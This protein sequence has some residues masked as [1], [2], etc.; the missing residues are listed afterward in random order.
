VCSSDLKSYI[1]L[2]SLD[3]KLQV[4]LFYCILLP[5]LYGNQIPYAGHLAE[6][7]AFLFS[8]VPS[9]RCDEPSKM[10]PTESSIP[11]DFNDVNE[12]IDSVICVIN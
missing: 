9:S 11:P 5:T 10:F 6:D 2:Q 12:I 7:T 3:P 1:K 8:K 4:T